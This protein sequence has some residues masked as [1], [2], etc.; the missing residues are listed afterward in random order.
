MSLE[1]AP[2]VRPSSLLA[3]LSSETQ[4]S[5]AVSFVSP[6]ILKVEK[7]PGMNKVF[8][9]VMDSLEPWP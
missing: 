3:P 1:V 4:N 5:K 6:V 7:A 8:K 2:C 9:F